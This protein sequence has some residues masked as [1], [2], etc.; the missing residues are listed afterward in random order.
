[1]WFGLR[2]VNY[3]WHSNAVP[4]VGGVKQWIVDELHC[5]S[6]MFLGVG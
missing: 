6:L 2:S 5:A 4:L 1:M 3:P